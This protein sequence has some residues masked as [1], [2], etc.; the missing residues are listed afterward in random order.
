MIDE[1]QNLIN[2]YIIWLKDKIQLRDLDGWIEITTPYLDRHNDYIQLYVTKDRDG[3]YLISDDGYT[4]GDL[5]FT[6]FS[7]DSPKRRE[8]LSMTLNS[9]GVKSDD[10]ALTTIAS[11]NTFAVKKHN[12]IQ[13]ILAVNDLFYLSSP[14]V[15]SL[16]LEDVM[17][18]LDVNDVR[19]TPKV[20]FTGKSGYD[21]LF[22]FVI[23][24]SKQKPE[25][26]VKA[27]NRP[28][29][30][31]AESFLFAWLDTR[32]IRPKESTSLVFLNN[33]EMTPLESVLSSFNNYGVSP[34][35]W[36]SRDKFIQELAA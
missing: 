32:E 5:E 33:R 3:N 31:Q 19:Y 4:I 7:F 36:T 30:D 24:K 22:D 29:K 16:F 1:I 13:S 12:L 17:R 2:N 6:G 28:T 9:Y 18:F 23:P 20:K 10:R 11:E 27:I 15:S 34:I 26:I 8:L 14:Y 25:R 35:L 21:H